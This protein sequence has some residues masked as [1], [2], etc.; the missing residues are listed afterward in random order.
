MADIKI[1]NLENPN[2]EPISGMDATF[3]YMERHNSP[4]HVGSVIV[5][6]G[7]LDFD[8]F[9]KTLLSRIHQ[10]PKLRKKLVYVPLSV[11]YPYWADDPDFDIDMHLSHIALPSPGSWK[12]LRR[13]AS[14]VF[15]DP[16]NQNRPLWSF[17]F[18]EGLD[19]VSQ[20]PKGSVAIIS[21]MHHV[22]I[23]GAAGA[24]LM[25]I[26]FDMMP[27]TKPIP[28]PRPYKPKPL[29]NELSLIA[30]S[31]MSFAKNPLKL[32]K[33]LKNTLSATVKAGFLSRANN[34]ELPTAPFSAPKT[35]LNGIV[36]PRKKWNGVILSLARVKKLN[37][38]MGTTLNDVMLAICAGA[39]RSCLLYTSDAAD[40]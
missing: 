8:T 16:L 33:L 37:K 14:D 9:K 18:V 32:P 34:A 3:L 4:M 38:T 29:P 36:S 35:Q 12:E 26:I 31:A 30:N 19:T 24:G 39:L 23:D 25:S 13:V 2:L 22:M 7:S 6:E 10:I 11:D 21:K 1:P 15:S 5:M 40:E 27:N 20:V 28:E 17:T